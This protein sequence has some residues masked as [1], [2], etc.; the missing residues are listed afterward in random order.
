M[1]IHM[2]VLYE[3]GALFAVDPSQSE[4]DYQPVEER[5][6]HVEVYDESKAEKTVIPRKPAQP[7]A[8]ALN[9]W[10]MLESLAPSRSRQKRRNR[11]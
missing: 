4:P 9:R 2:N 3:V 8:S 5:H 1:T 7:D 6:S 11:G 10:D